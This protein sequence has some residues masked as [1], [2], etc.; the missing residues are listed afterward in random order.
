MRARQRALRLA[1]EAAL[2]AQY[3][4]A[5]RKASAWWRQCQQSGESPYLTRKGLPKG[6]LYGARLSPSGNLVI[7]LQDHA[8]TIHGLQVIYHDPAGRVAKRIFSKPR[9]TAESSSR[10]A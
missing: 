9:T 7:P 6:K 5:S 10:P 1:G 2:R 3:A 8:G 4:K